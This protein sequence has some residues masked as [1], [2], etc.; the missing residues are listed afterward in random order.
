MI[1]KEDGKFEAQNEM[2]KNIQLV[3]SRD[4]ETS[5]TPM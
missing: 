5:E 4:S 3:V 1:T 2:R